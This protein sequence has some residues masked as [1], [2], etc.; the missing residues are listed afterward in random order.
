MEPPSYVY[1]AL[2]HPRDIR[3]IRLY[4][5]E[6]HEQICCD[7]EHV[8]LDY[9]PLY[10]ALSYTWGNPTKQSIILC[11][12]NSATLAITS[13]CESALKRLR[14]HDKA[15]IL[16]IDAI[17]IDQSNIQERNEQVRLMWVIYAQALNVLVYLGERS[18]D[19]AMAMDFIA[20][21][22]KILTSTHESRPSIGV[23]SGNSKSAQQQAIENILTRP[24]FERVWVLQEVQSASKVEVLCG[25][26]AVPWDAL[27]LTVTYMV[28]TL[29]ELR[30]SNAIAKVPNII[31][32]REKIKADESSGLLQRLHDT[33]HCKS[34]D[35]RDKVYA[36]LNMVVEPS[37]F[38]ANY[39]RSKNDA[40]VGVARSLI[41][42]DQ[43]LDVLSGVQGRPSQG[44]PSWVPDWSEPPL[45][46][47]LG[48]P[49][50][51][52]KKFNANNSH[53]STA[54]FSAESSIITV[55]GRAFDVIYGVSE[56][57]ALDDTAIR[58]TLQQWEQ[59]AIT[60]ETYPTGQD[61]NIAFLE[62]LIASTFHSSRKTP[63]TAVKMFSQSWHS[64]WLDRLPPP[65][66]AYSSSISAMEA[67]IFNEMVIRACNGRRFFTTRRG[68]M[69]LGPS[70]IQIGDT[71][72]VMLG[73]QVPFILRTQD[74][75]NILIG[76]SYVH[77]IM[78][79][80]ALNDLDFELRNFLIK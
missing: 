53:P 70:D 47:V 57:Y 42:R 80:E 26:R 56:K 13:N 61:V 77:G 17:S 15:Q 41:E 48:R 5:G 79:G 43:C 38:V 62:T 45:S 22:Y 34:T 1:Q 24:W 33:R 18:A 32:I 54:R 60:L 31:Y 78:N 72:V 46:D 25:D 35:P 73:G 76:E 28:T 21:D 58:S 39:N 75:A 4:P 37:D 14:Q 2:Q 11:K 51:W 20:A 10:E 68:Y 12:A 67:H 59:K 23:D 7:I 52:R 71:V 69:G 36:L 64:R 30:T 9:L 55:I 40:Y 27:V 16:W 19:S 3:L 44:L 8:C 66:I 74:D 65:D 63:H 50:G 6:D 49:G 29:K